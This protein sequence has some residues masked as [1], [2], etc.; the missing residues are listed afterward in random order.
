MRSIRN[1]KVH[2]YMY[3]VRAAR[4]GIWDRQ[5]L[6]EATP[7][8]L[9]PRFQVSQATCPH[10]EIQR[11]GNATGRYSRCKACNKRWQW[12][13]DRE[14]WVHK[15][16]VASSRSSALP[17]PSSGNTL[18]APPRT[19]APSSTSLRAARP[20]T[21]RPTPAT[22]SV[23]SAFTPPTRARL[24][25]EDE[26]HHWA[27]IN[28]TEPMEHEEIDLHGVPLAGR[29]KLTGDLERTA[30]TYQAELDVY[31]ALPTT[32]SRP[33]PSVDILEIFA[34]EAKPT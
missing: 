9:D 24:R 21:T 30:R 1:F 6:L 18:K 16:Y 12:D 5:W 29:R 19:S 23:T 20:K 31:Q 2:L 22:S 26:I 25:A 11:Y 34:G 32:S 27:L 8:K 17:L 13:G 4:L 14:R 10:S 15:P 3:M 28:D 33:P 7:P